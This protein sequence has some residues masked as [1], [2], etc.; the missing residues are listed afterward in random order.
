MPPPSAL[1]PVP[2]LMKTLLPRPS[3]A[4]PDPN[5]KMPLLPRRVDPVLNESFPLDPL[6]PV[7]ELTHTTTPPLDPVPSPASVMTFPPEEPDEHP[8]SSEQLPPDTEPHPT[9]RTMD[10]PRAVEE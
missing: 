7:F 2:T 9:A 5:V 3:V 6:A 8:E 10:P 1:V 4:A